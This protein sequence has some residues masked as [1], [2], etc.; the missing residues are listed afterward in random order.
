MILCKK[1]ALT[2]VV[3]AGLSL[4]TVLASGFKKQ[5]T[6]KEDNILSRYQL[7][8]DWPQLPPG[9]ILGNPTGIDIDTNGNIVVFIRA[10]RKWTDTMPKSLIAANT[11]LTLDKNSGKILTSWGAD[12]FIMP[13]GLTVDKYNNVW[14]TDVGLQ[15][16]FKFSPGGHLLMKLGTERAAGS[17]ES[18]FNMPTDVAVANDGSFYVSDGYGNNRVVKFSSG[19]RYLSEWGG[20]GNAPGAFNLPHAIDLD[21]D[22]NVY[23]ADRGN[24]RVQEFDPDGKFIAAWW[25]KDFGDIYSVR[26]RN[27]GSNIIA[28]DYLKSNGNAAGSDILFLRSHMRHPERLGRSG[29]YSGP[30]CRYHDI[31]VDKDGSIYVTD[32]LNN[33]IQKFKKVSQGPR[34]PAAKG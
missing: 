1:T 26:L 8:K 18:H 23:V 19:G 12:L 27:A 21:I 25:E 28:T 30:V 5:H 2:S 16:V 17:D 15:Q 3:I 31:A 32:I 24:K 10:D 7:V 11:I 14:V 20:K 22:G 9:Y 4:F 33:I 34:N 13:H 6:S 29:S